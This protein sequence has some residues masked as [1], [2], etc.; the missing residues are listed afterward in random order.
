M[1]IYVFLV[2]ILASACL[3]ADLQTGEAWLNPAP[4]SIADSK[5]IAIDTTD[6]YE[7]VA[8]KEIVAEI[9]DLEHKHFTLLTE[10]EAKYY[11]G[12]YYRCPKGKHPYLV[13][14]VYGQGGTGSYKVSRLG[15]SLLVSHGSLGHSAACHTSALVVNLE[16]APNEIY[17]KI[18]IAE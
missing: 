17:N 13:R 11:T 10:D 9:R 18:S 2:V 1:K 6:I 8:S 16:F 7:V 3:G 14:A 12:H 5:W 15:N 4:D